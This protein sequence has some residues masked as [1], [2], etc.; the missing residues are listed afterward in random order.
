[1]Y[2]L[3]GTPARNATSTRV[4]KN[5]T[6][7]PAD[8]QPRQPATPNESE[9]QYHHKSSTTQQNRRRTPQVSP[10]R[11]RKSEPSIVS[12]PSVSLKSSI[13]LL[14]ALPSY[15]N[16]RSE[17]RHACPMDDRPE[18]EAI[19]IQMVEFR[20]PVIEIAGS[21]VESRLQMRRMR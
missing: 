4:A 11:K 5:R 18:T 8:D 14:R 19:R 17:V 9:C 15:F 12:L 6:R 10:P 16:S 21:V 20:R 3:P 7:S 2:V 13:P 1:M